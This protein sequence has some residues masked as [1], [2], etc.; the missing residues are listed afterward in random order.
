MASMGFRRHFSPLFPKFR[1]ETDRSYG[2]M[3]T[4]ERYQFQPLAISSSYLFIKKGVTLANLKRV[5]MSDIHLDISRFYVKFIHIAHHQLIVL[6]A[7]VGEQLQIVA[8]TSRSLLGRRKD[9]GE[10][11]P[12]MFDELWSEDHF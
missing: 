5:K 2:K 10:Y 1:I 3:R 9:A 12:Y 11:R 7:R 6:R 8:V 4:Q